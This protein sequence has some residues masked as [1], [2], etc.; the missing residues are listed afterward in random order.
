MDLCRFLSFLTSGLFAFD[1]ISVNPA[2]KVLAE[3]PA[4][5]F[6][7]S[8]SQ[9]LTENPAEY[10]NYVRCLSPVASPRCAIG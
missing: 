6:G 9:V 5:H 4:E 7:E 10:S 1:N 3:N 2:R 8:C